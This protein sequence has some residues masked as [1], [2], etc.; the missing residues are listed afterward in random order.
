MT[1]QSYLEGLA[2]RLTQTATEPGFL[3]NWA[4]LRS[5]HLLSAVAPDSVAG[6]N[7]TYS[8]EQLVRRSTSI[9][10]SALRLSEADLIGRDPNPDLRRAAEIFEYLSGLDEGPSEH[11][12]ALIASTLY[13][14]AGY[15]AN[16][17]CLARALALPPLPDSMNLETA[18]A[19]LR[20]GIALA[21]QRRFVRLQREASALNLWLPSS[22]AQFLGE[23]EAEDAPAEA[24]AGL[25]IA[26]LAASAF[27]AL[28][29]F[30]LRG[31][32]FSEFVEPWRELRG[33]I[34]AVGD[35]SW[36]LEVDA[37]E[38]TAQ[39]LQR[40]SVW[41]VLDEAIARDGIWARYAMLTARGRGSSPLDARS[42]V[43]LWESQLR[44]VDSGLLNTDS[45][46]LAIR[47]PTS[48]GKTR[49]AEM[50]ILSELTK[51]TRR[52]VVYVAPFNALADE[53]ESSMSSLFANL[54]YRVTSVLG[55]YD[56]DELEADLLSTADLL[57]TTPEKLTL[58]L[59]SR[60][61][62]FQSVG[63]LVLDEG[64]I[65]DS[66][67][68][69]V[70]YELLLTRLQ[71][72]LLQDARI[73][74]LSA[75]ISDEN[76]ADFAEWLC[77]D[78]SAVAA[79]DWRPARQLV[80]VF[81]AQLNRIDYPLERATEGVQAPFVPRPI[82]VSQYTD[83]T[84]KQRRPKQVPF[85][86]NSKGD[87]TAELALKFADEG[88]VLIFTTQPRW[89]ESTAQVVARG[90]QL[91]RQTEGVG[92][93]GAFRRVLDR[94]FPPTSV[95]VAEAWLGR[96]SSIVGLLRQGIGVHHA[97]LPDALRRTAEDDFRNGLLPVLV[98][99]G[100]LAQGV[101]L[102]V[103]TVLIHT[104]HQYEVDAA[105]DDDSRVTLRDFWNTAGRAGRAGAE[106]E[107]HIIVVA[108]NDY[109]ARQATRYLRGEPE[110][111]R[112]R[113]FQLLQELV[114]DRLS[115]D[116]F[117]LQL[118]SDLLAELVEESVGSDAESRFE[119][120]IGDS[121]V[122]IQVRKQTDGTTAPLTE[123]AKSVLQTIRTEVGEDQRRQTFALT[124]LDVATCLRI[125]ERILANPTEV[126]RLLTQADVGVDELLP[127]IHTAIA[128]LP[129]F[130]PK[131]EIAAD[132][133]G[134]LVDWVQQAP[135]RELVD[136]YLP[137]DADER[138]FQKDVITDYFG[139]KLPWATSAYMR[140][141]GHVLDVKDDLSDTA[142]WLAPM[143]RYGV[144]TPKAT[145]A[146]T[147]GCPTR[148]LSVAIADT[149]IATSA[150]STYAAFAEWFSELT[151][152]DFILG[153]NATADEARLLVPRAMAL[154]RDGQRTTEL[155]RDEPS[156]YEARVAGLQYENRR[157]HLSELEPG[158][159]LRLLRDYDNPYD[160]NA[161][162]VEHQG[163]QLGFLPRP[164]ARLIA[165]SLDSGVQF[166][167][168]A[169][170]VQRGST[171]AVQLMISRS[172]N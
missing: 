46:G 156:A 4:Q 13:Q 172:N 52:Q 21:L 140:I 14:V 19:V 70:G 58:L 138:R 66:R 17:A 93:P 61:T 48:A 56:L 108:L 32:P 129:R 113:L 152:E 155:L 144:A 26:L 59:R 6:V 119:S 149:F 82:S 166:E 118:D 161:I 78:R 72:R 109:E 27:A 159:P 80:G 95:A 49:I 106:T 100:T 63:L 81:N 28:A 127:T 122:S 55:N 96:E 105:E 121:F 51:P 90:L 41:A 111:L 43:E 147:L 47:M 85:P 141:A 79:T 35:P 98:A 112:G 104:L 162:W 69:G 158:M 67:D 89:A 124:G 160:P 68:R 125:E 5:K 40:T 73:L 97:G 86:T 18:D 91:R 36:L 15:A 169:T 154:V 3:N 165:P 145:W 101:N 74:F 102:P 11:T 94:P 150:A 146:M 163:A 88:P 87:L 62:H 7:Y 92:I 45:S 33:L 1:R 171:A 142:R 75:V 30:V 139:Y 120:L 71:S 133:A 64:H 107:G 16:S 117:R 84:P 128:D 24:A 164:L 143:V 151:E 126:K 137:A 9:L 167:A 60:P 23:L 50:A 83:F 65:I 54:G 153:M 135:M 77:G 20:R 44:A 134:L 123:R 148:D 99:T 22:E 130:I 10:Q 110:S 168:K 42:G 103:K 157:A 38:A 57:I 116:E 25:P 170:S 39:R 53:V 131:F 8:T 132:M 37:M 31:Q 115:N 12:S 76:A 2:E 114:S 136:Q 29:R 34:L